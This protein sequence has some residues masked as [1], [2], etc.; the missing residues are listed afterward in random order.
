MSVHWFARYL[1]RS[2]WL[3][4]KFVSSSWKSDV[5]LKQFTFAAAGIYTKNIGL[6]PEEIS[7]VATGWAKAEVPRDQPEADDFL[8][9]LIGVQIRMSGTPNTMITAAREAARVASN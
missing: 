2:S 7:C 6:D 5:T 4:A 1:A 3:R 9:G 8:Q